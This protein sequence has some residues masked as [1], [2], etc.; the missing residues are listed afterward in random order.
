M[1]ATIGR[2][3]IVSTTIAVKTLEPVDDGGP[4]SRDESERAVQ[5]R[6]DPVGQRPAVPAAGEHEASRRDRP[7][8]GVHH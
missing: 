6:L 1:L 5:R 2:I 3:M 4:N 7:G 8:P